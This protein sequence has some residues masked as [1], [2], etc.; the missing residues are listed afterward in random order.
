MDL[1]HA[2]GERFTDYKDFVNGV[3]TSEEFKSF[4]SGHTGSAAVIVMLLSYLPYLTKGKVSMK[5]QKLLFFIGFLY[6]LALAFSRMLCGAHYLT[7]VCV[8]G[9]LS[10]LICM[11]TDFACAKLV[12][13]H[14]GD[15]QNEARE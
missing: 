13:K 10:I 6:T 11:I 1:Y 7:D 15:Y 4:P 5:H 8:G 2:F 3:F 12:E 9:F 14:L